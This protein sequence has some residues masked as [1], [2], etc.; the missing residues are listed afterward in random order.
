MVISSAFCTNVLCANESLFKMLLQEL[1]LFAPMTV[2]LCLM[3]EIQ[4][5]TQTEK[6][7]R[8][9]EASTEPDGISESIFTLWKK[10]KKF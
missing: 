7:A 4:R 9:R 8:T 6:I 1:I 5:E 2:K 10:I 3:T